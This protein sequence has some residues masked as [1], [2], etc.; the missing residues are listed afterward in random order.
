[1]QSCNF[2]EPGS[3][4]MSLIE[5]HQQ[6]SLDSHSK[7]ILHFEHILFMLLISLQSINFDVLVE[8]RNE[9][10]PSYLTMVFK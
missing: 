7:G 2:F 6:F 9:N 5:K 4:F 3:I 1:M 8:L 10:K